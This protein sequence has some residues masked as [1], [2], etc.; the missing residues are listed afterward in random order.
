MKLGVRRAAYR[1]HSAGSLER[2]KKRIEKDNMV[3]KRKATKKK[4][5]VAKKGLKAAK[6]QHKIAKAEAKGKW[7]TG[8]INAARTKNAK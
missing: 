2:S 8:S 5:K 7:D 6:Y 3:L 4:L 1:F